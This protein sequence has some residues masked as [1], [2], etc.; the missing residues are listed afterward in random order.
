MS[1][2]E[3]DNFSRN[4]HKVHDAIFMCSTKMTMVQFALL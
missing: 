3:T 2:S 1:Q 4:D